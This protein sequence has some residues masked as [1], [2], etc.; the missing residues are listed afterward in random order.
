M[1]LAADAAI[2]LRVDELVLEVADLGEERPRVVAL[3]VEVEVAA[4]EGH[5]PL[6]VGG[7]V[8]RERRGPAERLGLGPQ[9]AHAGRVERR[10]PHDPGPAADE[11]GDALLHLARGLV[12]EG[13]REHLTGLDVAGREQVGD[14][15]GEHPGLARAGPGDDQQRRALVD[16]GRPLLGVEALEQ[17]VGAAHADR[18][19]PSPGRPGAQRQRPRCRGTGCSSPV[20]P[21]FRRGHRPGGRGGGGGPDGHTRTR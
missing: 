3:R 18:R 13:D 21:R 1:W 17:L 5:Q 8:D 14:A 9:D 7:V 12:G 4:D 15:V 6:R 2:G 11:A 10:H 16:H 19:A 20:H